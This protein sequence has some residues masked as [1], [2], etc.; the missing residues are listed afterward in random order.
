MES[1]QLGRYDFPD[2]QTSEELKREYAAGTTCDRIQLL[3]RVQ[4]EC[5]G[6]PELLLDAVESDADSLP[7][8]WA[9]RHDK[10]AA[11]RFKDDPDA[12]VRAAA[13]EN[14]WYAHARGF[15]ISDAPEEFERSSQIERLGW[16]RSPSVPEKILEI[17]FEWDAAGSRQRLNTEGPCRPELE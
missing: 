6:I 8:A 5:F 2:A 9:A 11:S 12:F 10:E 16:I 7:R 14:P 15:I 3:E 13:R 1:M 17:V 4:T